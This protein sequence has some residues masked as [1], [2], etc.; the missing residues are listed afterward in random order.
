MFTDYASSSPRWHCLTWMIII[1]LGCLMSCDDNPKSPVEPDPDPTIHAVVSDLKVDA[2]TADKITISWTAPPRRGNEL[3]L[4]IRFSRD[5]LVASNWSDGVICENIPP[6]AD[7]GVTQTYDVAGATAGRLTYIAVRIRD[8]NFNY[9][10]A[11]IN[12]SATL[13]LLLAPPA[14]YYFSGSNLVTTD[15]DRDGDTDIVTIS[16]GFAGDNL[17]TL[18]NDGAGRFTKL[19]GLSLNE[20]LEQVDYGDFNNDGYDDLALLTYGSLLT[21]TNEGTGHYAVTDTQSSWQNPRAIQVGDFNGDSFADV[22]V[23]SEFTGSKFTPSSATLVVF[24]SNGTGGF[25]DSDTLSTLINL[26]SM[27]AYDAEG[28]GDLDIAATHYQ[29]DGAVLYFNDGTGRNWNDQV[30]P[31]GGLSVR[32]TAGDMNNDSRLDLIGTGASYFQHRLVVAS[33][34][35]LG[36]FTLN[37]SDPGAG[38]GNRARLGD[39]DGD[40]FL[41]VVRADTAV[42]LHLN[43]GQAKFSG[44][45]LYSTGSST[46][47]IAVDV[48]DFDADGHPDIAALQRG[49]DLLIFL[50][51]L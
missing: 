7:S 6:F 3:S 33:R 47:Q 8:V 18:E 35:L 43:D 34:N 26:A 15:V 4:D 2:V 12:V 24:F 49:G 37:V 17:V 23:G 20:G 51:S 39:F 41:D 28:D 29:L 5:T 27:C 11:P 9:G 40:G 13:P 14:R 36:D 16:T 32:L 30:V 45:A 1:C 22:A 46:L 50:S 21:L 42:V 48:A 10:P 44:A 25:A 31:I 38:S 19:Q